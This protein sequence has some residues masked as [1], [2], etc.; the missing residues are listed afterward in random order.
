MGWGRRESEKE[1]CP[2][3]KSIHLKG[4]ENHSN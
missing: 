4:Q 1:A 3:E 2:L